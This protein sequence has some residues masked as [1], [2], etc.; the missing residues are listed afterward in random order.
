MDKL[1]LYVDIAHP[2]YAHA[3]RYFIVEMKHR[4]HSVLVTARDK[5]ITHCLL[6][7]WGIDFA[8]RGRGSGNVYPGKDPVAST[9]GD[10]PVE[11][12]SGDSPV[13]NTSGD[14]LAATA[15]GDDPVAATSAKDPGRRDGIKIFSLAGKVT[16]LAGIT[17]RLLPQIRKF[18][19]DVIVSWSSYHAALIGRLLGKPVLTFE[20]TEAVPFQHRLNSLL[21][22][23]MITPACFEKDFGKKHV[24]FD[25]YKELASLHP[26]RFECLPLPASVRKPYIL[27]R[28]V[29]WTAYH[30]RGH[31]G[32]GEEMKHKI[33]ARLSESA[34]V[35]ISSE[36]PL[37]P[38]LERYQ[39]PAGCE[40]VHSLLAGASLLFGESA[41][42]AAEAA[43]LGVPAI[44]IDN[45]GRGYTRELEEKYGLLLNFREDQQSVQAALD[46]AVELLS[47]SGTH[48]RWQE[49]RRKMLAGKTDLPVLMAGLAEAA[50]RGSLP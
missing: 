50:A 25:G 41:S 23:R 45:T 48:K 5:D 22:T 16:Y 7:A 44:F 2:A 3:L 14:G 1:R 35:Y 6:N 12:T 9:S 49:K 11:N 40:M 43:V 24:R 42:M 10:S 15:S 30:D 37:S 28:F 32:I 4:G 34:N 19:P 21:S 47:D 36:I 46:R 27:L 39:L 13:E 8:S 18:N 31:P 17:A 33:A 20:D 38:G 26:S 29:S